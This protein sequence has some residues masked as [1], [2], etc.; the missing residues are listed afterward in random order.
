MNKI[1]QTIPVQYDTPFSPFKTSQFDYALD[2]LAAK[3]FTGAE[4][5]VAFPDKI[6]DQ[7]LLLKLN[8]AG[9]VATT[10][11]TGQAYGLAGVFLASPDKD[12]RDAAVNL[13]IGHINLS[14]KLKKPPVTI[15]LL[16]GK[17]ENE[18]A[19]MLLD[20]LRIALEPCINHAIRMGVMLQ[21]EPINRDETI[22]LNS[23]QDTLQF[24]F[25]I[26]NPENVGI[27]YDTYHSNKEDDTM[28]GAIKAAGSKITNVHFADSDRGLPGFAEIDFV[29]VINA[30]NEIDYK[31]AYTLETL[32]IPDSS[33]V[34][35]NCHN[36]VSMINR[37]VYYPQS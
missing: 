36:F 6:D 32:A 22:M 15:G 31:G 17:L 26:G 1:A 16:R 9:L 20:N 14:E 34:N 30:L 23:L 3:G 2:F 10:L 8:N 5:A 25:K 35:D 19:D 12:I 27:L 13:I 21:I 18:T 28:T 37:H 24:L 33:F 29:T 4:L 11:S 7:N